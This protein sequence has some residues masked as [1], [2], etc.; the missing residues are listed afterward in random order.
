MPRMLSNLEANEGNRLDLRVVQG[1]SSG[2][3]KARPVGP[4][5]GAVATNIVN[6]DRVRGRTELRRPFLY[7]S[8]QPSTTASSTLCICAISS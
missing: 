5:S 7:G 8:L 1:T 2:W 6:P 4:G 3:F